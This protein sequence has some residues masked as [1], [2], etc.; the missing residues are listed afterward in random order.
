M[1]EPAP[2]RESPTPPPPLSF[3]WIEQAPAEA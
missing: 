2:S 3:M 1:W